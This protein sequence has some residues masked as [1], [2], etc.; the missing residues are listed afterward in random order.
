MAASN[1]DW[2]WQKFDHLLPRDEVSRIFAIL[3]GMLFNV[4]E[5]FLGLKSFFGWYLMNL[6][7]WIATNIAGSVRRNAIT[8]QNQPADNHTI[9]TCSRCLLELSVKAKSEEN[10]INTAGARCSATGHASCADVARNN[11]GDWC[12]VLNKFIGICSVLDAEH[13]AAYYGLCLAWAAGD[14]WR[15]CEI[16]IGLFELNILRGKGTKWPML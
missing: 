7:E 15:N 12:F 13:W 2:R 3:C 8:F 5:V 16:E 10:M 9:I 11:N 1:G 4:S 14:T 6:H